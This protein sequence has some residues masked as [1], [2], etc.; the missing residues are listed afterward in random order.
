MM[1]YLSSEVF[2]TLGTKGE[3]ADEGSVGSELQERTEFSGDDDLAES[4]KS[5]DMEEPSNFFEFLHS[6]FAPSRR[7][8][9]MFF[10]TETLVLISN[11]VMSVS[12]H[13]I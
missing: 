5:D 13:L 11:S 10:E 6:N 4:E 7:L 1:K 2:P 12:Y 3:Y 9:P 8:K